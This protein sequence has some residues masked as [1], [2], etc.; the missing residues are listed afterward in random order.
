MEIERTG[1]TN[2]VGTSE[3]M[4]ENEEKVRSWD[5]DKESGKDCG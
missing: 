3:L 1:K 2:F 5:A 4:K